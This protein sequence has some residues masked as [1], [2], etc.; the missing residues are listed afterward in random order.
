[1][2]VGDA[3]SQTN[4]EPRMHLSKGAVHLWHVHVGRGLHENGL[5]IARVGRLNFHSQSRLFRVNVEWSVWSTSLEI[6]L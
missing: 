5:E 3:F 4:T 1:M 6:I 2:L